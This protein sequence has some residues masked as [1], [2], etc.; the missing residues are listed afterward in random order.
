MATSFYGTD[1][2]PTVCGGTPKQTS[3]GL[4]ATDPFQASG[5]DQINAQLDHNIAVLDQQIRVRIIILSV[6][7]GT[8]VLAVIFGI[9]LLIRRRRRQ[10][11]IENAGLVNQPPMLTNPTQTWGQNL[12]GE[13]GNVREARNGTGRWTYR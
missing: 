10:R 13:G 7:G 11:E 5:Y 8:F 4:F 3:S 6:V 1:L 2:K 12:A 9:F